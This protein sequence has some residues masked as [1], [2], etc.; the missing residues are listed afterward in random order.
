MTWFSLIKKSYL[1][2][3]ILAIIACFSS[4]NNES[5]MKI[6]V[7]INYGTQHAFRDTVIKVAPGT[8]ALE[9]LQYVS[10]VE[11]HFKG[12][13]VFVTTVDNV[14]GIRGVMAWYYE[15]N[16]KPTKKL[17]INQSLQNG[18]VVTWIY[19]TDVCSSKAETL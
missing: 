8:T 2:I 1:S 16:Q 17:A 3:I 12:K 9:A 10:T 4:C 18:D 5:E 19:K 15:V 14:K 7:Q 6:T 11:T 13:Y